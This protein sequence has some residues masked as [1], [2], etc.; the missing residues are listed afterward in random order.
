MWSSAARWSFS[1]KIL[2]LPRQLAAARPPSPLAPVAMR[3]SSSSGRGIT[4]LIS[5]SGSFHALELTAELEEIHGA[6]AFGS[7]AAFFHAAPTPRRVDL[8][9]RLRSAGSSMCVPGGRRSLRWSVGASSR[10][11]A[12]GGGGGEAA[13]SWQICCD[14]G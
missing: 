6:A 5:G 11:P 1:I 9:P 7:S 10:S 12:M 14:R 8:R 13:P 4:A 3:P 2:L